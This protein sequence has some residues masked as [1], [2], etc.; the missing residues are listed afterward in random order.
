MQVGDKAPEILGKNQKGEE[1]KLSDFRGKKLVLYFYPK[2][3]TSGC[4]AQACSLRDGYEN[5]QAA[6]YEVIGVSK[7]SAKSHQGFITKQDLP[8]QLIADTDTALNQQ[9]GVW[10]EKKMYGR[11]YMGTAR[12][13]FIINEEGIIEKIIGPKEVNTKDHAN[14]ILNK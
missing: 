3:N 7:D 8:F 2:D 10:V 11:S 6:G 12:T 5:L 14:Q 4:T 9:F 1:I 13:T